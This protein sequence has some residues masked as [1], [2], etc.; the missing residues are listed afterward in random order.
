FGIVDENLIPG[1]QRL[2]IVTKDVAKAQSIFQTALDVS[3]GTGKDLTAVST[4]L[5]KAYLG[6]N[7]ALGRL[8]VGLSKAQLK[9]ASFLEV[10]KTLNANFGGQASAAVQGYAGDMAKLTVAVDE[11][12]E[13]IGKGLLD[14]MKTLS[15]DTSID[16]FTNNMIK[17][18]N[19]IAGAFNSIA[20]FISTLIPGNVI[21]VNGE[22]KLKS[23]L[24]SS[25]SFQ[26]LSAI[27]LANKTTKARKDELAILTAS[28]KARSE[29]DKLKDKF[30][31]E[32]I[33]LMTALNAASDEE[34]K[35]RIKAQI[36]ILDNNEA[37][38]K[39]YN[40]ELE[41]ANS[42]MKLA[43]E[44]TATTDAMAKLRI[45]TKE[46]YT[47]KMYAGSSIYYNTYN[48]A[49]IPQGSAGGAPT[50]VNN[51]N[52]VYVEPKGDIVTS[53]YMLST[54]Q[55][56]LQRLQKQGSPTYAAGL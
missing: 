26:S 38:A 51:D 45:V 25:K 24:G 54:V 16:T 31:L 32:R 27:N 49:P 13:A 52:R 7:V 53:D 28:N 22:Y 3:A 34:T 50:I 18:A 20:R 10:Q 12:K 17:S 14:A 21:K 48:A 46:D 44:L 56:A 33:G 9:S 41:A 47:N 43:Q 29:I 4:S 37:L 36:A 1:F 2:L 23:E 42:A 30:D 39:K 6:D 35:L 55:E 15:G 19:V 8:G 40:A 5:S 11:S